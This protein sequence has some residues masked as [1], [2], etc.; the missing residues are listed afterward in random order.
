MKLS[1][2]FT[3]YTIANSIFITVLE[4]DSGATVICLTNICGDTIVLTNG[5]TRQ[6]YPISSIIISKEDIDNLAMLPQM[7][8]EDS[9]RY[10]HVHAQ[11][12]EGVNLIFRNSC[13]E[14]EIMEYLLKPTYMLE[15][16]LD[17][18]F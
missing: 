12:F 9:L 18:C 16:Y 15:S 8:L 13:R 14:H 4:N 17:R 5:E 6:I 1:A 2:N 11:Q 3:Y 10:S 7:C